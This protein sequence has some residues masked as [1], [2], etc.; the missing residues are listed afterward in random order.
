MVHWRPS[1]GGVNGTAV[2][3][4]AGNFDAAR[5]HLGGNDL[6]CRGDG[7]VRAGN[8]CSGHGRNL[9]AR[10]H[11]FLHHRHSARCYRT[12]PGWNEPA[13][14]AVPEYDVELG[15]RWRRFDLIHRLRFGHGEPIHRIQFKR[16][17]ARPDDGIR[18]RVRH[19]AG[20]NR[21]RNARREP[22]CRGPR[23]A[24]VS[25]LFRD[26]EFHQLE[27]GGVS[28]RLLD[29]QAVFPCALDLSF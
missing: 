14:H 4:E 22:E 3:F 2:D 27:R 28:R 15:I 19:S 10:H 8:S 23:A 25:L 29:R 9:A 26:D 11:G 5:M 18:G 16:I 6:V 20:S 21:P 17:D 13:G 24:R 7:G 12:Q 1:I